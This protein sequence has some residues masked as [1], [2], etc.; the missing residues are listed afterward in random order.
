MPRQDNAAVLPR[1][2]LADPCQGTVILRM[3]TCS[4][5]QWQKLG[6]LTISGAAHV[7]V[8]ICTAIWRSTHRPEPAGQI[9]KDKR[10]TAARVRCFLQGTVKAALTLAKPNLV[11][12]NPYGG[13]LH[14]LQH[15]L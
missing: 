11:L 10:D 4:H 5:Q 12:A 6:L 14:T 7:V 3:G 1:T 8:L 15:M 9:S 2:G 13:A